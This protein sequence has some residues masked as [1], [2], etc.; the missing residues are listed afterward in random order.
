VALF[1]QHG[2]TVPA[3]RRNGGDSLAR[4]RVTPASTGRPLPG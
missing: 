3:A 4:V 2:D 1:G